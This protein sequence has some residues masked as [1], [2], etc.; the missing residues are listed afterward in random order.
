[1]NL[2]LLGTLLTK[3]IPQLDSP[4]SPYDWATIQAWMLIT[5]GSDRPTCLDQQIGRGINPETGRAH[6]LRY[7]WHTDLLWDE[8]SLD[9]LIENL[10]VEFM[11]PYEGRSLQ[12]GSG[13]GYIVQ[14]FQHVLQEESRQIARQRIV[15]PPGNGDDDPGD[16]SVDPD[17]DV[18]PGPDLSADLSM[19]S[20]QLCQSGLDLL[21]RESAL[22]AVLKLREDGLGW[23]A[24]AGQLNIDPETLRTR[25][26]HWGLLDRNRAMEVGFQNTVIGSWMTQFFPI[27]HSHQAHIRWAFGIL[28]CIASSYGSKR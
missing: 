27:D 16:L 15:F 28:L 24:I 20:R 23:E 19:I 14:A 4:R 3:A 7:K 21:D 8:M 10:L 9:D 11:N 13:A 1:M 25:R 26:A 22:A 6:P 17:D 18:S 5:L 2:D 12:P